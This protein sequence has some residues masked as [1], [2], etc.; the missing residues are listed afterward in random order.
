MGKFKRRLLV[1]SYAWSLPSGC[2]YI[3]NNVNPNRRTTFRDL[4]VQVKNA[5]V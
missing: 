5:K 4:R 2:G 3:I 1:K